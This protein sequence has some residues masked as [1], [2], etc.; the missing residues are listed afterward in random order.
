MQYYLKNDKIEATFESFGAEMISLKDE[1]KREYLWCADKKF[2][3]RHS[4]VLFPF[5]GKVSGGVYRHKGKE[6]PMGQH[7]FARDMEFALLS[8][9]EDEIWFALDSNEETKAK[10]P[11]DFRLEIGYKLH[12]STVRVLWKVYNTAKEELLYFSIGAHPAFLCPFLD[13]TKQSDY[14]VS[15]GGKEELIYK[16][17]NLEL[18]LC[19]P[20]EHILK[21]EN[22]YCKMEQGFFDRDTYI[23]EDYQLQEMSLL[24][25]DKKPY[26]TVSFDTPL[27][28]LW[29]PNKEGSPF[30]CI[31]P[32]FGRC[33]MQGY[34][35]S[36]KDRE[37][38]NTLEA[39]KVFETQYE[40]RVEQ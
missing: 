2:W 38:G 25:P 5:V 27:V 40:I 36:L 7:G 26:V 8:Q 20:E 32:W 6:Y 24:T 14:Y 19:L 17:P 28:A 33:D 15:F 4:P 39:G 1:N 9:G 23:F 11:F 10:Y 12:D 30:V 18:G 35:G 22:G 16:A 34:Q 29:S 13:G 21:A 31:E 3:G 37:W